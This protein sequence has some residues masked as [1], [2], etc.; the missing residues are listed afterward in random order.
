MQNIQSLTHSFADSL[1]KY[2]KGIKFQKSIFVSK[3]K[4]N[5]HSQTEGSCQQTSYLSLTLSVEQNPPCM[6]FGCQGSWKQ[7]KNEDD[8]TCD[9]DWR[10]QHWIPKWSL[11]NNTLSQR[12]FCQLLIDWNCKR[13]FSWI[14]STLSR[15]DLL[16][17]LIWSSLLSLYCPKMGVDMKRF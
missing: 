2:L 11:L 13:E 7:Q 6:M 10:L 3:F 14:D 15:G 8:A 9:E 1:I 12:S 4:S 17:N 5:T 16:R